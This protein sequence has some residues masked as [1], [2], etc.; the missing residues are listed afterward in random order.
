MVLKTSDP[1]L[2]REINKFSVLETIRKH[3]VI[4]RVEITDLTQ[5]SRTTVSA[6]TG[7]LLE[8]GLIEVSHTDEASRGRPRV[9]LA[10]VADAAYAFG[11]ALTENGL[12]LTLANFRG[13]VILTAHH[14]K[15]FLHLPPDALTDFI[16]SHLLEACAAANI[17]SRKVNGLCLGISGLIDPRTGT[18]AKGADFAK[19]APHLPQALHEKTGL[20]IFLE[21]HAELLAL[22]KQWYDRAEKSCAVVVLNDILEMCF[23]PPDSAQNTSKLRPA[24]G[25]TKVRGS[26][27][28]CACGQTDCAQAYLSKSALTKAFHS[29]KTTGEILSNLAPSQAKPLADILGQSLAHAVNLFNPD[30]LVTTC[31]SASFLTKYAQEITTSIRANATTD[32][33]QTTKLEFLPLDLQH[34]ALGATALVLKEFYKA[35]WIAQ[36]AL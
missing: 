30:T 25:H 16:A 22:K 12:T 15:D 23:L 18:C 13:D 34:V 35:P 5:L 2:M 19:I 3:E 27:E 11:A 17:D 32:N 28:I 8:T 24:L 31:E 6:I 21:N 10:L 1:L 26:A 9:N 29:H 4:S 33:F 20:A 14:S 36:E 7:G